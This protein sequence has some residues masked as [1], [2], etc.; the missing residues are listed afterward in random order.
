[1]EQS[2]EAMTVIPFPQQPSDKPQQV[3]TSEAEEVTSV[4]ALKE[5]VA[6]LKKEQ[7]KIQDLLKLRSAN[8]R[9]LSKS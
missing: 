1:M 5:L 4:V 8:P 9:E 6:S 7:N 3:L 2:T